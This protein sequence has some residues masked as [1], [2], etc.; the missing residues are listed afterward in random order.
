LL[1]A[2]RG[3]VTVALG[4]W[5]RAS[6]GAVL[7]FAAVVGMAVVAV[8]ILATPGEDESG[9][10]PPAAPPVT[11]G[12]P[13]AGPGPGTSGEP[14]IGEATVAA[15]ASVE[16]GG[17]VAAAIP[18]SPAPVTGAGAVAE[19]TP[20]EEP[21]PSAAPTTAP[22]P[23]STTTTTSRPGATTT[24]TQPPSGGDGGVLSALL[25]ALGLG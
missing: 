3:T 13:G 10:A 12:T 24:T 21:A 18:V 2:A 6:L 25:D 11:P 16:R 15:A 4:R 7:A 9:L 8:S 17:S 1:V 5:V 22:R 14:V 23:A 20:A 19:A